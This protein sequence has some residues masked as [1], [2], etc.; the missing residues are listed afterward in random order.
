[1][2]ELIKNPDIMA[3]AQAE[4]RRAAS[5][6]N[7]FDE[8]APVELNYL[9]LVIKETLRLHPP[10][11]LLLPRLCKETCQLLGYTIPSNTIIVVNAWALGRDK[12]YWNDA[13]E[14]KP[15]RFENSII[16]FKGNNFELLP[17]GAGRRSCPG[18]GFGTTVV[19]TALAKLLLHFD[20]IL[21][22]GMRPEDL[23]MTEEFGAVTA[24]KK[25]LYV[26]PVLHVPLQDA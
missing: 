6:N 26:I 8:N 24:R 1:M 12:E 19:E 3:K 21:P 20:W 2:S 7:K 9:K 10:A 11:P 16:D 23:D 5:V 18:I 22:D 4:V 17:F 15:E 25:P 14:F 13:E